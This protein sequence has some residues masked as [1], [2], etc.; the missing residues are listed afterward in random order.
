MDCPLFVP[1]VIA[2][3]KR[4]AIRKKLIDN[5]IYCPVHWPHPNAECQ[6]NLYEMELSLVCDQRYNGDDMKR[7]VEVLNN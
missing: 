2:K 7:I 3:E 6:S 4:N 1:I 5:Q